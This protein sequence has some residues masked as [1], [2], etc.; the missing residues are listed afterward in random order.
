MYLAKP[1][2]MYW[3]DNHFTACVRV[4][5]DFSITRHN[6]R[7]FTVFSFVFIANKIIIVEPTATRLEKT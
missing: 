3:S 2:F 1:H 4:C 7:F 5:S 6:V